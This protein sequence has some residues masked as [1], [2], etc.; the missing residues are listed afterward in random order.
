MTRSQLVCRPAT[1]ADLAAFYGKPVTRTLRAWVLETEGRII[2]VGGIAYHRGRPWD[3]F[4]DCSPEIRKHPVA[5][6]KAVKAVLGSVLRDLPAVAL[7]DDS[8]INSERF[9]KMLGLKP[10]GK[11]A[12][13]WSAD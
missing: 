8:H 11:R 13:R 2:A 4:S 12:Y 1:S 3:L 6:F 10:L 5:T 7:A 9:L